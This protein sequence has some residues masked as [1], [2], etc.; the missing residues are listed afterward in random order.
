MRGSLYRTF[1]EIRGIMQKKAKWLLS[2]VILLSLGVVLV[3][4]V[5]IALNQVGKSSN[6]TANEPD[7]SDEPQV[8]YPAPR[9]TSI[10]QYAKVQSVYP[11]P[12]NA[13]AAPTNTTL[14]PK[15][16]TTPAAGKGTLTADSIQRTSLEDAKAAFDEKKAVFIDVRSIESFTRNHV[17]EAISIPEAQINERLKELD[18]NQWII[19]YCS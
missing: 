16:T 2:A 19:T 18:P 4:A 14:A 5:L 6:P 7:T 12:S 15:V 11:A 13:V 1:L 3:V 9:L 17:P 10:E 8:V